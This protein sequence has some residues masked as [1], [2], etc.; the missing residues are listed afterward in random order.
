MVMLVIHHN[1]VKPMK[2]GM[3]I[4]RIDSFP[5]I[6]DIVQLEK[7]FLFFLQMGRLK[8]ED[9]NVNKKEKRIK[10]AAC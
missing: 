2:E 1:L 4:D 8:K 7:G 10:P 6:E 3:A 9:K 5:V